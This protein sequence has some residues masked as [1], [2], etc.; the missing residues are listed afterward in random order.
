MKPIV[1]GDTQIGDYGRYFGDQIITEQTDGYPRPRISQR[2]RITLD[3]IYE[4]FVQM[5]DETEQERE[6][7]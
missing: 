4:D 3:A 1:P 2:L 7:E 6:D 5:H